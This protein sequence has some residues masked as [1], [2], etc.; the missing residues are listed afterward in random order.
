MAR[1]DT[2]GHGGIERRSFLKAAATALPLGYMRMSA[3]AQRSIPP[4]PLIEEVLLYIEG[5]RR[6][7]GGY[8]W[9]DQ[10][11]SHLTPSFAAIG[12]YHLLG[13][14]PPDKDTLADFVRTH[15]PFEV[16]ALQRELKDFEFQQIKSL[17]WL[18][19]D[20]SSFD[21]QIR[22]WT[23]PST[24]PKQYEQHGYPVLHIEAMTCLC[25]RLLG[26]SADDMSTDFIDYFEQRRRMNGSFNNT[27]ATDDS[28]GHVMN[29]WWGL[30]ALACLGGS[31][32]RRDETIEWV[33]GCQRA[34]GGF[35][36]QPRP[37]IAGNDDIAYT[38]AA[39]RCL[40]H[41]GARPIKSGPCVEHLRSLWNDEGG[42]ASRPGWP[43]DPTATYRALDSLRALGALQSV[44][45][46][47]VRKTAAR[48]TL[49]DGL[50]VYTIQ[51]EAHGKGSPLEAV[52]M[53]RTLRINLWGAKNA[54]PDWI[55]KCQA[56]AD[57]D[58]V[59]VTFF[60]ANE[61]YGT[62]VDFPGMGT[63][64]H[65]SDI[66]APAG[67]DFGPSLAA[68]QGVS[69]EEF[70]LK[71]LAPLH[72]AEGRLIWQ[73]NE[74]E[75]LTRLYLDDSLKRGGYAA[76]STFHF[77][78][79]DFTNYEPFLRHYWRQIPFVA[80]QDAHGSEPWWWGDQL[81]GFRTLFLAKEPTWDGWLNALDRNW[82][83][84]VRHDAVSA[85]ETWM[86]GGPPE[87]VE[88]VRRHESQWRWWDNPDIQRPLVSVVA[89]TP[90]D[91]WEAGRP[92][93]GVTVRVRC[94][95]GNT[96][97]GQPKTQKVELIRLEIDGWE[98][99]TELVAPKAQWGAYQDH[100]HF[101]HLSEPAPGRH[102]ATATVRHV[103]TTTESTRAIVFFV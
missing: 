66:V 80:L 24:Y 103:D 99:S 4:T 8:A 62:F 2:P 92:E 7:D 20:A 33:Q 21:E 58:G 87:A 78:N 83:V 28:D 73:F 12:C 13:Q 65:T 68:R 27:P 31:E 38:W 100:Y 46:P 95:W 101:H 50:N 75:E 72:K 102:T 45:R 77:G 19:E 98:V 25:R 60:V 63:Y 51:I 9:P 82:V 90:E 26:L 39:V 48:P 17:Q 42:F 89:L 1:R 18:G 30:Q 35:T 85:Y 88:F 47:K 96:A 86:H 57:R 93:R 15:H 74:N 44:S 97:K 49:P 11:A 52:E 14:A 64:S 23:K 55:V 32:T 41:F 56:I 36:Y 67:S 94:Y 79:P 69:W 40:D 61:E 84:A 29:T 70:R 91:K 22:D 81:T 6:S 10:R 76:I 37:T 59:P 71:R 43:S 3:V 53:A 5:L 54:G 34:S 16:K